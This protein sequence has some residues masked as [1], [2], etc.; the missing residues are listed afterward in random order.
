MHRHR[1]PDH[2]AAEGLA[3][4]LMAEA[5]AEDRELAGRGLDQLEA[6]AGPVRIAGAGG[7]DD[8]LGMQAHDLRNAG[9]VVAS[10]ID[11]CAEL[12]QEVIEVIGETVVVI[13]QDE[14]FQ[15]LR[16]DRPADAGS[17]Q[18]YSSPQGATEAKGPAACFFCRRP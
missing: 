6:D 8:P 12:P 2:L 11:R 9:V 10:D 4:G 13:D 3:D 15:G 7:K 14:H 1:P 5:D 18:P 17:G 16:L